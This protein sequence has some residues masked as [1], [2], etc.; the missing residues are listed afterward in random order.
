[1]LNPDIS[2]DD[3][4]ALL[5]SRGADADEPGPHGWSRRRFL[6]AI[7]AGLLGGALAGPIADDL[8][9]GVP[10]TWAGIAGAAL[11]ATAGPA[12]AITAALVINWRRCSRC[13][14]LG[15]DLASHS[16]CSLA[17]EVGIAST[18]MK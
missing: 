15:F 11:W 12:R 17:G 4:L 9:G 14:V 8:W 5:S 7:G 16:R 1:M 6:Q 18:C 10:D 13:R 3:A 2:T